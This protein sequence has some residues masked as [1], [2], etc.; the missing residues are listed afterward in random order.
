[1]FRVDLI[2]SAIA[3][4][5]V[6]KPRSLSMPLS[7]LKTNLKIR[8]SKPNTTVLCLLSAVLIYGCHENA[9]QFSESST[10]APIGHF[11]PTL[12]VMGGFNSCEVSESTYTPEGGERAARLGK[13]TSQYKGDSLNWLLSCFDSEGNIYF[14]T[15]E[16]REIQQAHYLNL[17]PLLESVTELANQSQ[18]FIKGH[19]HGGWLA[20]R[21]AHDLPLEI[22]ISLLV[23]VDPISAVHC[24]PETFWSILSRASLSFINNSANCRQAPIDITNEMRQ[25][26]LQRLPDNSWAH[27]YQRN[28]LPLASSEFSGDAQPHISRDLSPNFSTL[29]GGVKPSVNAHVAIAQIEAPWRIYFTRVFF[30]EKQ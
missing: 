14:L 5:L 19:S 11:T 1:M 10:V 2:L 7:R 3:F 24:R 12:I 6:P 30:A 27:F 8:N 13:F 9:S 23:T 15:S 26:I 28:F 29:L 21:V 22:R 16:N 20:M 4:A 17:D 25:K 18:V